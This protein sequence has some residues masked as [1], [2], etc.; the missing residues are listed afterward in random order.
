VFLGSVTHRV[1]QLVDTP[2]LVARPRRVEA[3]AAEPALASAKG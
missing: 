2:V 1:M 3:K